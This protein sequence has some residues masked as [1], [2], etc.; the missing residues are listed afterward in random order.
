M[1]WHLCNDL[2][3]TAKINPQ[4]EKTVHNLQ[5]QKSMMQKI[6]LPKNFK[7]HGRQTKKK[8]QQVHVKQLLLE[9]KTGRYYIN[10]RASFTILPASIFSWVYIPMVVYWQPLSSVPICVGG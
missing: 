5:F 4:Q 8:R 2:P 9:V 3:K 7:P 6:K 10:M 1:K